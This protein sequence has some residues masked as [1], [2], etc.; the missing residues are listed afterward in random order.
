MD[1][2]EARIGGSQYVGLRKS[3]PIARCRSIAESKVGRERLDRE[4]RHRLE[5]RDLD[6]ATL[7]GSTALHQRTEHSIG[8]IDPGN[9]IGECWP[10]KARAAGIDDHAQETAQR[11]CH[12]IV[13]RPLRIRSIRSKPADRCIDE[14]WIECTKALMT[15]AEPRRRA[16]PEVLDE[17]IG[18]PQQAI[19]QALFGWVLEVQRDA[20]FVTVVRL[21]MRRV[22]FALIAAVGIAI[23]AFNLDHIGAK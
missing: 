20:A 22:V 9:G 1:R 17:Y 13:A 14:A 12:R 6:E 10:Q 23:G 3:R 19:E 2:N 4:M 8:G 5:H 18:F 15:G 21:K 7:A 11:L 16:W